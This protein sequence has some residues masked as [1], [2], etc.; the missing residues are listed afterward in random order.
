MSDKAEATLRIM[1]RHLEARYEKDDAWTRRFKSGDDSAIDEIVSLACRETGM[2]L[3][4]YDKAFAGSSALQLLQKRLIR[5]AL[6][7][8]LN[9]GPQHMAARESAGARVAIQT[10]PWW[11]LW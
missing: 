4:D 8:P 10:R 7:R 6:T 1:V 2:T 9:P 11:K 5:D 3:D